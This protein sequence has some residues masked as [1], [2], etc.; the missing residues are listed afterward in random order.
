MMCFIS[1]IDNGFWKQHPLSRSLCACTEEIDSAS[2]A[3]TA[4]KD[5]SSASFKRR[6][7]PSG[8]IHRGDQVDLGVYSQHQHHL[9]PLTLIEQVNEAYPAY[10]ECD[11]SLLASSFFFRRTSQ[12][13]LLSSGGEKARLSLLLLMLKRTIHSCSMADQS[14]SS[15]KKPLKRCS[16][17]REHSS[18]SATTDTS[19]KESPKGFLS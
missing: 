13:D 16:A 11:P 14:R 1:S 4:P 5:D 17:M 7:G 6:L 9:C 10:N 8:W 18:L 2:S 19:S 15:R 12:S 3:T